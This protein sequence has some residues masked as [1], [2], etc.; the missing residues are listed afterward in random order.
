MC[1]APEALIFDFE[2]ILLTN[3]VV[4]VIILF[5]REK[6]AQLAE[7]L[8]F[9]ER[10]EG[11]NPSFL[12]QKRVSQRRRPFYFVSGTAFTKKDLCPLDKSLET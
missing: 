12:I 7:H 11:S 6:L 2:G 3:H 9:K 1:S 8:P 5:V 4:C 10:V